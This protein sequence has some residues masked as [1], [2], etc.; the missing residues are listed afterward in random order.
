MTDTATPATEPV[1]A[2][3]TIDS[4]MAEFETGTTP[5]DAIDEVVDEL[6]KE[7][8]DEGDADKAPDPEESATDPTDLDEEADA[9]PSDEDDDDD[10]PQANEPRY[11]VKV[12]GE[13][14]EVPLS[15]LQKGYSRNEDYKLKTMA[16]ADERRADEA[17]RANIEQDVRI[18][19]ANE[20]K[21]SIDLFEQ[22]DPVLAEARQIDWDKLKAEDPATFVQYS[23]AVNQRIAVIEQ[24]RAQIAQI[25]QQRHH[26]MQAEDQSERQQR[27]EMAANKIV[28]TMPELAQGDNFSTFANQ[29]IE[30]LREAG[31]T[32]TEIADAVDDRVL[33]MAD[34]ARKWRSL[35]RAKQGLPGKKIVPK[36]SVRSMTSDAS[37]QP[38]SR[39]VRINPLASRDAR[40]DAVL[41][42]FMKE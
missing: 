27:M 21:Q 33:L 9:D 42:E 2:S 25:E 29:N 3:D 32:P 30:F 26:A 37:E 18:Q 20:L 1:N 6:V 5:T 14:V 35:Q 36:S 38:R 4:V 39:N 40:V 16:L 28:E 22:L 34:D 17:R 10:T 31:F 12:N 8:K 23:D 41:K 19:Y 11:K 24:H 15:E 13:E 7:P